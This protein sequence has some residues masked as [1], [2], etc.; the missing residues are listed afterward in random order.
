MLKKERNIII[1]PS[2]PA[3]PESIVCVIIFHIPHSHITIRSRVLDDRYYC[4]TH[5]FYHSSIKRV[6]TIIVENITL[7]SIL[8]IH[9]EFILR[10]DKSTVDSCETYSRILYLY[11]NMNIVFWSSLSHYRQN[12]STKKTVSNN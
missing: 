3:T 8:I 7:K 9:I 12:F 10:K 2:N 11:L 5:Q 6:E 1:K 4:S